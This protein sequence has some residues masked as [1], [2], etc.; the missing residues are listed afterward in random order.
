[1]GGPNRGGRNA[2]QNRKNKNKKSANSQKETNSETS[3]SDNSKKSSEDFSKEADLNTVRQQAREDYVTD[4]V[5]QESERRKLME[6]SENHNLNPLNASSV[7]NAA[8]GDECRNQAKTITAATK[9][10][11][12]AKRRRHSLNEDM[13][14]SEQIFDE[15]SFEEQ[16]VI[17][18][19]NLGK[20]IDK[21]RGSYLKETKA[22]RGEIQ[23]DHTKQ[24]TTAVNTAN[25]IE[26]LDASIKEL[27]EKSEDGKKCVHDLVTV[28]KALS[29]MVEE[30]NTTIKG[31]VT[32]KVDLKD[33]TDLQHKIVDVMKGQLESLSKTVVK[34]SDR[35][36][37]VIQN[38]SQDIQTVTN[39]IQTD[40]VKSL[41]T[42]VPT[43]KPNQEAIIIDDETPNSATTPI[44]RTASSGANFDGTHNAQKLT[45]GGPRPGQP[46]PPKSYANTTKT[47]LEAGLPVG[48]PPTGPKY[49]HKQ[50]NNATFDRMEAEGPVMVR[51]VYASFPDGNIKW[52]EYYEPKKPELTE[53]QKK[54]R[55][56][57]W[58]KDREKTDKEVII[59]MIPTRDAEGRIHSRDYDNTQV[60]RLFKELARGGY[61]I[62]PGDIN[63]TSR[64]IQND[65]HPHH[66]PI[67]VTCKDKE[68]ANN[69]IHAASNIYL[70][71]GRRARHDDEE[72]GRFGFFRPSLSEQERKAI[73]D[74][75]KEKETPQGKG[76]AELRQRKYDSHTGAEE[77]DDLI[78]EE[79]QGETEPNTSATAD[80]GMSV[81]DTD[82]PTTTTPTRIGEDENLNTITPP[83][84]MTP[85]QSAQENENEKLRKQ[86]EEM[87]KKA[88]SMANLNDQYR[89]RN[90]TLEELNKKKD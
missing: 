32:G 35:N 46:P 36:L 30:Q 88:E 18:V 72:K 31:L 34:Y 73:R 23:S 90:A 71:G 11:Q 22:I 29:T 77:W 69:V 89:K 17:V 5:F 27:K 13:P 52:N 78:R 2:G 61:F 9:R 86:V 56:T 76:L 28:V 51:K 87:T 59:F 7:F 44:A 33:T 15:K 65:R 60:V 58:E 70:N 39:K 24:A 8:P 85:T 48:A 75:K 19:T 79:Y 1:M 25:K 43:D 57:K 14:I 20:E 16:T 67:T 63:G 50:N 80:G 81:M 40:L 45:I 83:A 12:S 38:R 55:K 47:N 10:S 82:V 26:A 42:K 84:T 4:E 49:N 3:D 53:Q 41:E 68:T 37:G 6:V 64:Q 74:K 54:R 62:K 21:L 66:L